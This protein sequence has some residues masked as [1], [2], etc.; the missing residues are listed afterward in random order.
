MH[1]CLWLYCLCVYVYVYVS[2]H[3]RACLTCVYV[4]VAGSVISQEECA[5]GLNIILSTSVSQVEFITTPATYL[6][7]T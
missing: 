4:C 6:T 2:V 5:Y 3:R 1:M 7:T